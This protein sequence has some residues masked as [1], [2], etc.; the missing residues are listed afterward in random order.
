[1][2]KQT[3]HYQKYFNKYLLNQGMGVADGK[4]RLAFSIIPTSCHIQHLAFSYKF[5]YI[6]VLTVF[7]IVYLYTTQTIINTQSRTLNSLFR[8]SLFT[9]YL[10]F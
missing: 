8:L 10:L 6:H 3:F 5:H 2:R 7:K 4:L 1:M 9:C